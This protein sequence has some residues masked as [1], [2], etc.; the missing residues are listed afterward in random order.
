MSL[1][2]AAVIR[3]VRQLV[4]TVEGIAAAYSAADSGDA[5]LPAGITLAEGAAALV[6]PG[7]TLEYV[8]QPG[9]H[10]HTYEVQVQV[11]TNGGDVGVNT[12]Q[13]APMPDR[14]LEVM[15]LNTRLGNLVTFIKF[16]RSQGLRE[17]EYAGADNYSG[18]ELVFIASEEASAQPEV[19]SNG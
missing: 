7:A 9:K 19:G 3:K 8:L 17:F 10:R 5:R 4:G 18:Y 12:A 2:Q 16:S 6:V 14:V 11:L 15:A 13:M 1:D